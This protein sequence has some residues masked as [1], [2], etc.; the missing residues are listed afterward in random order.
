MP[1]WGMSGGSTIENSK[2]WFGTGT[3]GTVHTDYDV[4]NVSIFSSNKYIILL[5]IARSAKFQGEY[6]DCVR[7]RYLRNGS[8][9]RL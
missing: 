5:S 1:S 4:K 2:S 7:I 3:Y 8:V 6:Y 9:P